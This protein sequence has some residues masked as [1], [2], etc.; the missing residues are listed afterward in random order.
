M[1]HPNEDFLKRF[2]G[3]NKI[4]PAQ[5]KAMLRKKRMADYFDKVNNPKPNVLKEENKKEIL[6]ATEKIFYRAK[7][8]SILTEAKKQTWLEKKTPFGI[9]F[10]NPEQ[11]VWM[12]SLGAI[13][14][15]FNE[16]FA[17]DGYESS[18]DGPSSQPI[19]PNP[20]SL[21]RVLS[22]SDEGSHLAGYAEDA[23]QNS[24]INVYSLAYGASVTPTL[25]HTVALGGITFDGSTGQKCIVSED[26]NYLL[27]ASSDIRRVYF[28][29]AANDVLLQTITED[30]PGFGEKIAA[31]KDFYGIAI[32]TSELT[33]PVDS[34]D[35]AIT[36][37]SISSPI[38]YY[39]RNFTSASAQEFK[40][41]H[42]TNTFTFSRSNG[43]ASLAG[44]IGKINGS[45]NWGEPQVGSLLSTTGINRTDDLVSKGYNFGHAALSRESDLIQYRAHFPNFSNSKYN[46]IKGAGFTFT[47]SY[48]NNMLYKAMTATGGA[49][50]STFPPPVKTIPFSVFTD[51]FLANQN[52]SNFFMMGTP[53]LKNFSIV[54]NIGGT[55]LYDSSYSDPSAIQLSYIPLMNESVVN[56]GGAAIYAGYSGGYMSAMSLRESTAPSAPDSVRGQ[57]TPYWDNPE[58]RSFIREEIVSSKVAINGSDVYSVNKAITKSNVQG[59]GVTATTQGLTLEHIRIYR[60]PATNAPGTDSFSYNDYS[61][62]G[63]GWTHTPPI[64]SYGMV[65]ILFKGAD[66]SNLNTALN[67]QHNF[68]RPSFNLLD[69]PPLC[70]EAEFGFTAD[71]SIISQDLK[72]IF[73][74]DDVLFVNYSVN[75]MIFEIDNTKLY[76]PVLYDNTLNFSLYDYSFTYNNNGEFFTKDL[77]VYKYNRITKNLDLIGTLG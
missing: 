16:F 37:Y 62:I 31:D 51:D 58:R 70:P 19:P 5:Q 9:F 57:G 44:V 26:G 67:D 3:E 48:S 15:N 60:L 63:T 36:S 76:R 13:K 61:K 1:S 23:E 8:S 17:A 72:N 64:E 27:L 2:L 10:F 45:L 6:A 77:N 47:P 28:F 43:F 29:D 68:Y 73:V 38:C 39:K 46:I 65:K 40:K 14:K 50:W 66:R 54:R 74:S 4:S 20:I 53:S 69:G 71:A 12:N 35:G 30:Y 22:F 41:I 49:T 33:R 56:V 59:S 55:H 52:Q 32:S 25:Q 21:V 18:G 42:T 34:F 75:T 24:Y 7:E 11:Q